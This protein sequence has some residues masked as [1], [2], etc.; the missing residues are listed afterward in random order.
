M[1]DPAGSPPPARLEPGSV[2]S[3]NRRTGA[4]PGP[5]AEEKIVA[6]VKA[7]ARNAAERDHRAQRQ[8]TEG[9]Q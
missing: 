6:L 9:A 3:H 5:L 8:Q 1:R 4:A 2:R 7:L